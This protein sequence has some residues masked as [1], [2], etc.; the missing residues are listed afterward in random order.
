MK[1]LKVVKIENDELVFEDGTRLL[2]SHDQECYDVSDCQ[3][4]TSI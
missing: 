1:N 2:S 3:I 4:P